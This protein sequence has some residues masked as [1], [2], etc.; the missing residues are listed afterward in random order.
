MYTGSAANAVTA[1][2]QRSQDTLWTL[3]ADTGGKALLD[4]NDLTQGIVQAQKAVSSYYILGYYTTNDKADGKFRKVKI[5]LANNESASLDYRQGYYA[6]KDFSKYTTA[7][8]ERQLEDALMLGDPVTDLTIAMEI[9][10]FQLNRA[11]YFVSLA[12]KFRAANWR[13]PAKEARNAHASNSSAKSK[14]SSARPSQ[15]YVTRLTSSSHGHRSR[16]RQ[17]PYRLRH[18][19]HLASRALQD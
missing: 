16:T 11:E 10:Y 12:V 8:K 3:A 13:S 2:L 1:N 5:A 7:D 9:G 18:R 15:T 4:Y 6:G 19:L 17:A 14:M